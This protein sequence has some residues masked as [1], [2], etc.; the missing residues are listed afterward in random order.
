MVGVSKGMLPVKFFHSNKASFCVSLILWRSSESHKVE[1][2]LS[3]LSFGDSTEF[4][5]VVSVCLCQLN[6]ISEVFVL[7]VKD[8]R[9][10]LMS[11]PGEPVTWC[12]VT[13]L[14]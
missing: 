6:I 9:Y 8:T 2:N 3:I 11:V 7:H 1:E 14:G 5:I 4:T 10:I 12:C 13:F